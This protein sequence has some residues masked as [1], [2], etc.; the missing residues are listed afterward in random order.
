LRGE[1]SRR[2]ASAAS[3]AIPSDRTH[4]DLGVG[5]GQRP[6][7]LAFGTCVREG[8]DEEVGVEA[9]EHQ[10]PK[11]SSMKRTLPALSPWMAG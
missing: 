9:I 6:K 4:L 1:P 7:S 5:V 8:V 11:T 10:E 3:A 2:K